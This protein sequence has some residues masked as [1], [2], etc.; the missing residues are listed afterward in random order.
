MKDVELCVARGPERRGRRKTSVI[1]DVSCYLCQA[2]VDELREGMDIHYVEW[3]RA[4]ELCTDGWQSS[5][6][7][8]RDLRIVSCESCRTVLESSVSGGSEV[9]KRG[10]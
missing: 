4:D 1:E 7:A 6:L 3:F 10:R 9:L 8:T 5:G 2:E